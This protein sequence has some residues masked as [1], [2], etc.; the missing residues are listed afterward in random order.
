MEE[1][2]SSHDIL[3]QEPRVLYMEEGD[4]S[5]DIL[6]QEPRVLYMEE[7]DSSLKL[8]MTMLYRNT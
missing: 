4:S 6:N 7:G 2:D 1:G 8:G 5:H 3:N